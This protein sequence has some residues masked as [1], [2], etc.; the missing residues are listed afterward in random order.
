MDTL[1]HKGRY[2]SQTVLPTKYLCRSAVCPHLNEV[3][4]K[5]LEEKIGRTHVNCYRGTKHPFL[6]DQAVCHM[7]LE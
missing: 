3:L 7:Q 6:R 1:I 4:Q 5:H 2:P